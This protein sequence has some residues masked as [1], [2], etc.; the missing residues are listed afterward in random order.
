MIHIKKIAILVIAA[1]NQAVYRHYL[2]AYWSD[3]IKY[4]NEKKPNIDVFLLFEKGSDISLFSHLS[5]NIIMDENID[6]NGFFSSNGGHKVIPGIL[7]KTIFAFEFLKDKY[8]VFFRTNLSS[9]VHTQNLEKLVSTKEEII[10][11]GSGI[12]NDA[13]RSDL[14]HRGKI[15]ANKSIK[16][17][18]EL[19]EYPG[20]TFISGSAYLLGNEEVSYLVKNKKKIRYDIIDDVSIGLMMKKHEYLPNFTLKLLKSNRIDQMVEMLGRENFCHVRLQHFPVDIAQE[21]WQKIKSRPFWR[22]QK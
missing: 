12:W 5:E 3:M 6:F 9:M 11:S 20:N 22:N 14:I 13:L 7:S 1:Q 10:Y 21:L 15:G 16:K 2:R 19:D 4:T 8:D 18:G 17:I